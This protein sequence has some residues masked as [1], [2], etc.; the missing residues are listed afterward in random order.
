MARGLTS[1][2]FKGRVQLLRTENRQYRKAYEG[3]LAGL[4]QKSPDNILLRDGDLI[5]VFSVVEERSSVNLTGPVGKPGIFFIE[6]GVTRIR[7]V[8]E[9]AGGLLYFASDQAEVTRV[10]PT[11]QGPETTL[12]PVD[13]AAALKGDP[14]ANLTLETND[15]I[16]VRA[17]PQWD[18]YKTVTIGGEVLYPGTYTIKKG[19]RLSSLIERAG[20]FTDKAFLKGAVFT[21]ASVAKLQQEQVGR[22]VDDLERD[23]LSV[24]TTTNDADALARQKAEVAQKK[25]LLERLRSV[26][27]P[28]RIVMRLDYPAALRGS[29]YDLELEEGDS[30]KVSQNPSTV[31]VLG[32]VYVPTAQVFVKGMP[33]RAYLDRSGGYLRSAHKRMIYLQRADGSMERLVKD[34]GITGGGRW[35]PPA[36]MS[37]AVEVGDAI[38]VPVKITNRESIEAFKEGLD[39]IYKVAVSAGVVIAAFD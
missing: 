10:K 32:A 4:S 29:P 9:R 28:G 38:V 30:L 13:L 26:R 22:M 23:L 1:T 7:D 18:L 6:P 35:I 17:V 14:T 39:I 11:Q 16:F 37:A 31:Q 5:R 27:M 24:T 34:V 33:V 36:G 19:D 2:F 15:Y 8:I 12:I 21:R 3:S 25:E 20:G